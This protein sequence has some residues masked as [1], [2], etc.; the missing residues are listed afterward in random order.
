MQHARNYPKIFLLAMVM[1]FLLFMNLALGLSAGSAPALAAPGPGWAEQTPFPGGEDLLAIDAVDSNTAWAVGD[2]GTILRTGD[3]GQTWEKQVSNIP[4]AI[5]K[6]DAVNGSVA[7]A[8]AA[9]VIINTNDGGKTWV[10]HYGSVAIFRAV[11]LQEYLDTVS[12]GGIAAIDASTAWATV[13]Y[14]FKIPTGNYLFPFSY[15][16]ASTIW[17][18]TD[19]GDSW[20]MQLYSLVPQRV[21]NIVAIDAQR[22]WAVGGDFT[23]Y[24]FIPALY[25]LRSNDSGATWSVQNA[26]TETNEVTYISVADPDAA[27]IYS[28]GPFVRK[29]IDGGNT[30]Q[31]FSQFDPNITAAIAGIA[32]ADANNAWVFGYTY[33]DPGSLK[34]VIE[35]TIDGGQAWTTQLSGAPR[36]NGMIALDSLTA[37]AVGDNG[38]IFK[39]TDGGDTKPVVLSVSPQT[40][41]WG[42]QVT[43]T[44]LRFGATQG[45]SFVAGV[46]NPADYVSWS[47]TQIVV[48]VP[49]GASGG[50]PVIVT[51]AAGSSNAGSLTVIPA[52][53]VT[54][55]TPNWANTG[56]D[57][58][59]TIAGTGFASDAVVSLKSGATVISPTSTTFVSATQLTSKFS[60][61]DAA[62]G[63]YDM[64]VSNPGGYSATLAG[65]FSV[66]APSPCGFGSGLGMLMLGISLGLLSLAGSV[67]MKRKCRRAHR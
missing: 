41:S 27:W 26:G 35:K 43:I 14:V 59:V 15:V 40:A 53:S 39:T 64:I 2:A 45:S 66:T 58:E 60:L 42:D 11:P 33:T 50:V 65:G 1:V 20:T 32:A 13:S 56:T 51:T 4:P 24:P 22:L 54:S 8:N 61:T 12:L 6:I 46:E 57:V 55:V 47:N 23:A 19:G 5:D 36:I 31:V 10:P 21:G 28:S 38:V 3:G 30:W 7:W 62:V 25:S 48:K 44:G 18:T 49:V 63:T 16:N 34:G 37:W 67:R 52:M 29:T 17:K 9:L